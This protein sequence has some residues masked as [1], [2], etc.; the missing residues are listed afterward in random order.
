MNKKRIMAVEVE[1][2]RKV[3]QDK[4]RASLS[5]FI[6]SSVGSTDFVPGAIGTY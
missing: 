5:C 1:W 6:H 3:E 2:I 4:G